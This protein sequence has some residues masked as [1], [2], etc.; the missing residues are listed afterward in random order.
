[1]IKSGAV[2]KLP[3]TDEKLKEWK[4]NNEKG[5]MNF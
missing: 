3:V 4:D 2:D 5:K 1:M